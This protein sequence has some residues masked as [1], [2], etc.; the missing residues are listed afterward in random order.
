M[1]ELCGSLSQV[2]DIDQ[3]LEEAQQTPFT[4]CITKAKLSDPRKVRVMSYKG[5]I[6]LTEHITIFAIAMEQANFKEGEKDISLC[7]LF[8]E[9]LK[10]S[11]L[12]WFF[13]LEGTRSITSASYLRPSSN[14]TLY[15]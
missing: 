15:S 9:N 4:T 12:Q 8:V 10:R 14:I 2:Q 6:D 7:L 13:G 1:D 11:A 3:T 5:R